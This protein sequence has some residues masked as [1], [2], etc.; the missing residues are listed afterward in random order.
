[1]QSLSTSRKRVIVIV[2]IT[3]LL[4]TWLLVWSVKSITAIGQVDNFSSNS[5]KTVLNKNTSLPEPGTYKLQKIFFVPEL[6]VLDTNGHL[7]PISKYTKDKITLLTFFYQHC[8]DL[9]GCPYAMT[10][11]HSVK[12]KVERNEKIRDSVRFVH[13]S[14]DPERDTPMMMAG[15]E[16]RNSGLKNNKRNIDWNFLTTTNVNNLLPV[17]DAFG[18]NVDININPMTNSKELSYSHV[19][20]VFLIDKE[21]SVREIYSTSYMSVDMLFN[22]IQTL[23][24]EYKN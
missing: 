13:I 3:F 19:L 14:F 1:M 6:N 2:V 18:Q 12:N 10:T 17:I 20:K 22:D 16:K 5:D 11:F 4:A 21:G 8:S 7:Q 23:A 15:L 9:D 24:L